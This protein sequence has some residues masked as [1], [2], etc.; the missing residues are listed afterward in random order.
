[1]FAYIVIVLVSLAFGQTTAQ[2]DCSS[3]PDGSYGHGCQSYT[4][5]EGG[6]GVI[7]DCPL[8]GSAYDFRTGQCEPAITVPP[9]CGSVDN[10]CTGYPDGRYAIL[11]SCTYFYTCV[12]NTFFGA[13]PCN[14]PPEQGDL[15]FDEELEACNW[16]W[17]MPPPCG[18]MPQDKA[19]EKSLAGLKKRPVRIG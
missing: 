15:R 6:R 7:V 9:P 16:H 13:N 18:S 19:H 2:I 11:P 1:M 14:N 3:V 17:A 8:P 5:C 12:R 4:R 10:N